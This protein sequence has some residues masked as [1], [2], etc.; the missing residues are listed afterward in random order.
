MPVGPIRATVPRVPNRLAARHWKGL[1]GRSTQKANYLKKN[2]SVGPSR[3]DGHTFVAWLCV[4]PASAA[5]DAALD[6][7]RVG[8]SASRS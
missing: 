5:V 1:N 8:Q 4:A 7:G 2:G 6:A 3:P